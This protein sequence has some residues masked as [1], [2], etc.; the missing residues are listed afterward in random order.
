MNTS[1]KNAWYIVAWY[2]VGLQGKSE[3]TGALKIHISREP[4]AAI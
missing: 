2:F 4:V 3:R 1:S